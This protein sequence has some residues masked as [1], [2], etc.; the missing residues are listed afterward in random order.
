MNLLFSL[1]RYLDYK[2]F[3]RHRK[4]HGIHSP[5][6]FDLVQNVFRK[7]TQLPNVE[8][9]R[10][11]LLRDQRTIETN[12]AG[13]GS[14]ISRKTR[15]NV[16]KIVGK[17]SIKPKH[18]QL[19]YQ[20][21]KKFQ[22]KTIL[23][24]GTSLGLSTAYMSAANPDATITTV[25]AIEEKQ[26]I[27]KAYHRAHNFSNILYRNDYFEHFL[28]ETKEEVSF[29]FIFLDGDHNYA[30]SLKYFAMLKQYA[31][32]NTILVI[33]DIHW[34]KGMEAAWKKIID[35]NEITLSVDLYQMG[36]I[37]FRKELSKEHQR[38]RY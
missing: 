37:F 27:A 15:I 14:K 22:P 1:S 16:G 25:E 12:T 2:L 33:D 24:L 35:A 30:S 18:G 9:L 23:E 10:K 28:N 5:F 32:N 13:A 11:E 6:C 4:G 21:V 8:N 26:K 34:S 31:H 38:I 7:K 36:L 17:S 3:S 29:D 19:I 20:L